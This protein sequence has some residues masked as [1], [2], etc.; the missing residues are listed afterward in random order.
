MIPYKVK[1]FFDIPY[2]LRKIKWLYQRCK[3]GFSDRDLGGFDY[4][5]SGII[6]KGLRQLAVTH[7]GCPPEFYDEKKKGDECL[8]WR[9]ILLEIAEGF[10][11]N[12]KLADNDF[13]NDPEVD[14]LYDDKKGFMKNKEWNDALI[15]MWKSK[16][17]IKARKQ[18]EKKW[19]KAM[20]LFKEYYN[21]FWD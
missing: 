20:I 17:Y 13:Y 10:E 15:K 9:Q 21:S 14:K 8:A 6:R 1:E 19:E 7:H 3:Y 4:Y 16:E 11:A 5:L 18:C 12:R 2:Q